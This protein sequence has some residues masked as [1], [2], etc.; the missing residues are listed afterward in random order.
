MVL[1]LK[2]GAVAE[3]GGGGGQGAQVVGL[4]RSGFP[5]LAAWARGFVL[6]HRFVRRGEMQINL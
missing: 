1:P 2:A 6:G 4:P 3:V 5:D